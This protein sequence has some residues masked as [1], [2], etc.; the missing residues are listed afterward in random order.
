M[1]FIFSGIKNLIIYCFGHKFE[2]YSL[3][4]SRVRLLIN[5]YRISS[6]IGHRQLIIHQHIVSEWYTCLRL[7]SYHCWPT[8]LQARL[9]WDTKNTQYG[10][11]M[12]VKC[13]YLRNVCVYKFINIKAKVSISFNF[14]LYKYV[15]RT[16]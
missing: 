13:F 6:T 2:W 16:L 15:P 10:Y 7:D 11:S 14:I 5:Y 9:S 4:L 8:L 12:E 3:I 1:Y